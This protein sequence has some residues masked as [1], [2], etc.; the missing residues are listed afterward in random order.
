MAEENGAMSTYV[1][2]MMVRE[3]GGESTWQDVATVQVPPRTKRKTII[4][5]AAEQADRPLV[6]IGGAGAVMRVLDEESAAGFAVAMVAGPARL[7]IG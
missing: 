7:V 1:V 4:E 6:E 5:K 2:Q 3:K